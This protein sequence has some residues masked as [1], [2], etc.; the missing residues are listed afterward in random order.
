M[1]GLKVGRGLKYVSQGKT[2]RRE[3][4]IF[5]DAR[6]LMVDLITDGFITH[7]DL[8]ECA[9][10]TLPVKRLCVGLEVVKGTLPHC[11]D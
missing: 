5:I 2:E 4:E 1:C 11:L 7:N 8:G 10:T 6:L 3:P 9:P